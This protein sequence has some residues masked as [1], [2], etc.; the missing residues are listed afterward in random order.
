MKINFK[1]IFSL[2]EHIRIV[3]ALGH[4]NLKEITI[5]KKDQEFHYDIPNNKDMVIKNV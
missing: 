4:W 5:I 1:G 3:K 2:N